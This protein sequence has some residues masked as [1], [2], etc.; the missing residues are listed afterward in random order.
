MS[1][2][3][4]ATGYEPLNTLKPVA[5]DIWLIDGPALRFYGMPYSTRCT[6]IRL[7]SGDLWVHSPTLLTDNLRDEIAV[8]GPVR[9]LVAPNWIHYS[10]ISEW[11]A[12]YP[13]A[14]SF[15]APGVA[16]RAAKKG[17]LVDFDHDLTQD[18]PAAWSDEIDQ[19]I[20]AGSRVHREAVFFHRASETLI[21]ADLI[22]NFE[23]AKLPV[24][25]RPL[26]WI[27][28]IDDSDGKMPLDMRLTFRKAPLADCV[29]RMIDWGPQRIILAHGRWYQRDGVG[30]LRRAFRR[31]L[32]DREW[33]AV[34]DRMERDRQNKHE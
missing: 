28:G 11:Q 20:V 25:M 31:I 15:A 23:T 3:N 14:Q 2:L 16:Q 1:T 21:L 4:H 34:M 9:Y 32:R 5:P 24:W 6:V 7:N 8:L 18:A 30:E 27:A 26:V 10:H 29:E 13:G 33:T 22:E 12:A 19:M 17:A